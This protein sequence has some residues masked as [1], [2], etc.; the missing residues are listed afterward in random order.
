MGWL[1]LL[2]LPL[3]TALVAVLT[4]RVTILLTLRRWL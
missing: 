1:T 4:A 3:V 2:A